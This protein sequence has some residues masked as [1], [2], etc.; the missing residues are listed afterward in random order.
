[1]V[2]NESQIRVFVFKPVGEWLTDWLSK[3]W[4]WCLSLSQQD[5]TSYTF[6]WQYNCSAIIIMVGHT[7]GRS[8]QW[9]DSSSS[10][11]TWFVCSLDNTILKSTT[12]KQASPP[13]ASRRILYTTFHFFSGCDPH[14]ALIESW[15]WTMATWTMFGQQTIQ[16]QWSMN[17]KR[18]MREGIVGEVTT[19][20]TTTINYSSQLEVGKNN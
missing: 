20:T 16:E 19:K 5:R 8:I 1:M 7:I 9:D 15:C 17:L 3:W 18:T 6:T 4:W 14:W 13:S 10:I 12:N 2:R 11:I